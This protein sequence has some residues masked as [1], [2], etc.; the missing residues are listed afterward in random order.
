MFEEW[1][2]GLPGW[3]GWWWLENGVPAVV[4][5]QLNDQRL[6]PECGAGEVRL[7]D[8]RWEDLEKFE[9]CRWAGPIL[10]PLEPK[11]LKPPQKPLPKK[12]RKPKKRQL[13]GKALLMEKKRRGYRCE[14][15]GW[16]PPP[17]HESILELHHILPVSKGRTGERRNLILLCPTH[18]RLAHR[19]SV[20]T[21]YAF[22]VG[23]R[24]IEAIRAAET[25]SEGCLE[26]RG[27][28]SKSGNAVPDKRLR[29]SRKEGE[30]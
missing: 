20:A 11:P 21:G 26:V 25:A 7:P 5:V 28:P 14:V 15:C 13:S 19:V 17:G 4:Y 30:Q 10:E 24:L 23:K 9:K 27:T 6:F 8:G 3:S 29:F 18:H 22:R 16:T 2:E 12:K 1:Q